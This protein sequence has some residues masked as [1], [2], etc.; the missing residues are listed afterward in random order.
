WEH[1]LRAK[2]GLEESFIRYVAE[3][4]AASVLKAVPGRRTLTR[5]DA[6][7]LARCLH[8]LSPAGDTSLAIPAYTLE[9]KPALVAIEQL[10]E[11]IVEAIHKRVSAATAAVEHA[12]KALREAAEER[13]QTFE[14]CARS[15]QPL[16]PSSVHEIPALLSSEGQPTA[17][18]TLPVPS[19]GP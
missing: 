5:D 1:T 6:E 15:Q 3:R 4:Y 17:T 14:S 8:D 7:K 19:G 12:R 9:G 2:T 18:A 10:K 16:L 11:R 13:R